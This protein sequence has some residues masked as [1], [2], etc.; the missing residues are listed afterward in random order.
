M[1]K[2][3]ECITDFI[4]EPIGQ[5]NEALTVLRNEPLDQVN[6]VERLVCQYSVSELGIWL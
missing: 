6:S 5:V 1:T 2:V 4:K 3:E